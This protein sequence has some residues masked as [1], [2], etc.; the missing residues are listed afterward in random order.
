MRENRTNARAAKFKRELLD[1]S[2]LATAALYDQLH[3]PTCPK[4]LKVNTL[5][6][7][8][9]VTLDRVGLYL[10]LDKNPK[11]RCSRASAIGDIPDCQW[12]VRERCVSHI[13]QVCVSRTAPGMPSA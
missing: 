1:L 7:P 9:S 6:N 12:L 2:R 5:I 8:L 11:I 13:D 4:L 10:G 3:L